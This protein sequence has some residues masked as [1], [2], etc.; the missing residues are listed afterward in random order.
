MKGASMFVGIDISKTKLDIATRPAGEHFQ[1]DNTSDGL[2]SLIQRLKL[3]NTE[4]IVLEPSG[5][6]EVPLMLALHQAGLPTALI[7]ATRVRDFAK[8][9]G[10]R[11]KNDRVDAMMMALFAERLRPEPSLMLETERLDLEYWVVRRSQLIDMLTAERNRL[12][13][14][15]SDTV[16]V[17]LMAHIVFLEEQLDGVE[18]ELEARVKASS[19]WQAL[20]EVLE[21]VPGVGQV[22]ARTLIAMLPELGRLDR[23]QIAALVGVAPFDHESGGWKGQ[24]FVSGGRER[25]RAVLY[26]AA[27][28]ARRWNPVVRAFFERLLMAGKP[29]KVCLTACMRKLLVI[30]NAMV[31]SGVKF[32]AGFEAKRVKAA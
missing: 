29:F 2:T 16:K 19:A 14:C 13:L 7:H 18:R 27:L 17:N 9:N 31:K 30:L 24:R 6:Y 20:A 22:T 28:S 15:W 21:S 26:M 3:E 8:A 23:E 1:V 25:V 32:D 12:A 11:A 5:G 4:L 10:K